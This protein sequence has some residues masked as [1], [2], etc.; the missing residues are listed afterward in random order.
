[1]SNIDSIQDRVAPPNLMSERLIRRMI[2]RQAAVAALDRERFRRRIEPQ[3]AFLGADAA[4]ARL[5][6]ADLRDV[7]GKLE[8][9][10]VA[11]ATVGFERSGRH[12][13]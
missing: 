5:R 1:M 6:A 2:L 12:G 7:E 11:V 10:A 3:I 4:V 8:G 9:G 13:E